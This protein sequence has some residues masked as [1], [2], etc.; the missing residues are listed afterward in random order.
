MLAPEWFCS[1]CVHVLE[2]ERGALSH[3][4]RRELYLSLGDLIHSFGLHHQ[5]Y[6]ED[7]CFTPPS[8]DLRMHIGNC[9]DLQTAESELV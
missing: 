2:V 7:L 8:P 1:L 9:E 5:V 3:H 6:A 4:L